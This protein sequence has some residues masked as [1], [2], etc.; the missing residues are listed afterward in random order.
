MVPNVTL[1]WWTHPEWFDKLGEFTTEDCI[2]LFEEW[3]QTAFYHF[4][5]SL[6][7]APVL[8]LCSV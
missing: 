5:N 7:L 4:G 1:H 8:T 2:P 3:A 6:S